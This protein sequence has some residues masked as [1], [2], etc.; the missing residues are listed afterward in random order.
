MAPQPRF[1]VYGLDE[2]YPWLGEYTF[3][4]VLNPRFFKTGQDLDVIVQDSDRKPMPRDLKRW[5]RKLHVTFTITPETADG[6]AQALVM[7]DGVE[8]GRCTWW[9]IKP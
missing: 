6:V 8:V 3:K 4:L 5:G 7:R 9:V 1:Q 2:T